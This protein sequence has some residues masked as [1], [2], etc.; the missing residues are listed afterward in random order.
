M[1]LI[2]SRRNSRAPEVEGINGRAYR[3]P[4]KSGYYFANHFVMGGDRFEST[5]QDIYLFGD[6][7]DL[8]FLGSRPFA[9]PYPAPQP[10]EPTKT[11]K[12]LVNIRKDSL[13]FVKDLEDSHA[14][15]SDG[16]DQIKG[17]YNVEFTFDTDVKCAITIFYFATE[18]IVNKQAIYHPRDTGMNSETFHYKRGANQVFSQPTHFINP[19][20]FKEEDW[21][22][23]SDN[24]VIPVVIQC[25]VEEEGFFGHSHVLFAS[26]EKSPDGAYALKPLKQKQ[27]VDGLGYLL[28][29]I[30]GI[31]NKSVERTKLDDDLEDSGSECVICM[32]ETRDT[33]ILP[34]RHL[35]LCNGCADNLRYQ[36]SNCPICRVKFCALLQIRAIRRKVP[37]PL[38]IGIHP[39]M[40]MYEEP[41]PGQDGIPSGYEAVSLIEALNGPS[42]SQHSGVSVLPTIPANNTLH[43][44]YAAVVG[45]MVVP[46][47]AATTPDC[48][49]VSG[50]EAKQVSMISDPEAG[51]DDGELVESSDCSSSITVSPS[52]PPLPPLPDIKLSWV[53]DHPL[54]LNKQRRSEEGEDV[55]DKASMNRSSV[56]SSVD[57]T[58]EYSSSRDS[59]A[60]KDLDDQPSTVLSYYDDL[61]DND[62]TPIHLGRQAFVVTHIGPVASSVPCQVDPLQ[63]AIWTDLGTSCKAKSVA[64]KANAESSSSSKRNLLEYD[65]TEIGDKDL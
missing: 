44:L 56:C 24:E 25:V 6:N 33:L 21:Q 63:A 60:V 12:C 45:G 57:I 51:V 50:D 29:E 11:L 65:L 46:S 17:C 13:R 8:N 41:S 43:S 48:S 40:D 30:Y 2:S 22:Y 1:G 52:H 32:C 31:E 36:A 49:A 9:F 14:L 54:A 42:M 18:E 20:Q 53:L 27:M 61:T 3:Y 19:S 26:A 10:R 7:E 15:Q 62:A 38:G 23:R 35:C 16:N 58:S 64:L 5:K 28:Q 59:L 47:S 34:C 39:M 4:P 37:C 55:T